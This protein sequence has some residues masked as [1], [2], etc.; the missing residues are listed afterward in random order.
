LN[1]LPKNLGDVLKKFET[2]LI[3]ELNSGHLLFMIRSQF[4]GVKAT[5][6]NKIQGSTFQVADLREKIK[7]FL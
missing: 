1:P 7:S 3:P 5:G 4:P 2:V 6:I